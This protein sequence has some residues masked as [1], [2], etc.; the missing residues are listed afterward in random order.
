VVGEGYRDI[1][2]TPVRRVIARRLAESKR[3]IPHFY[4]SAECRMDDLL[5][6]RARL[7]LGPRPLVLSVNDFVIRA[8]AL[9]LSDVPEVNAAWA[10]DAIRRFDDVDVAVAVSTDGG[11]I[12]PIIRRADTKSLGVISDEM[13]GLAARARSGGLR[14]AEFQGGG[15]TISNL[16]M[17][18]VRDFAAI[19]NP[20]QAAILAVGVEARPMVIDGALAVG[21]AMTLTLSVDHR[22]VD[23][24]VAARFLAALKG[25]LQSPL[26]L[27][28]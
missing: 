4:L 23:G 14:P 25:H 21:Q 11:L 1:P 17:Y 5:A 22:I 8:C 27:L 10:E 12:T 26:G 13:A 15:F 28:V 20:P 24:A 16:G 7:R 2:L 9:A 18:G 19:I 3:D 6:L